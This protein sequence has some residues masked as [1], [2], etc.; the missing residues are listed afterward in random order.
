MAEL[1]GCAIPAQVAGRVAAVAERPEEVRKVG[2]E[3]ATEL[4]G[5]LLGEGV[6]GLHFYT[7]NEAAATLE[8]CRNLG[9]PFPTPR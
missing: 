7:M 3:I 8:I 2:V 9:L 6:P 5:K 4:C 1:S